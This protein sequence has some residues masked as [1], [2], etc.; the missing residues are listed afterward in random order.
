MVISDDDLTRQLESVPLVEAPDFREAVMGSVR[1]AASPGGLAPAKSRRYVRRRML[2]GLAWAA[3][4]VIVVGFALERAYS[5]PPQT[6]AATMAPLAAEEWPVVARVRAEGS[7]LTVRQSGDRFAVESAPPGTIDWD[8]AKLSMIEVLPSGTVILQRR[9]DSSGSA[10]I[11]LSIAGRQIL[12][13]SIS[14]Q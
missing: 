14:L 13:T 4:V 3:A 9:Q 7:T 10:E 5:P 11:R 6:A 1:R 8:R 12:K 2:V